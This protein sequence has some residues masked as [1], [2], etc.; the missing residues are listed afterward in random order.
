MARRGGTVDRPSRA[1]GKEPQ[2]LA[3]PGDISDTGQV[4][5]DTTEGESDGGTG[6]RVSGGYCISAGHSAHHMRMG[7]S[8]TPPSSSAKTLRSTRNR[9]RTPYVGRSVRTVIRL[10][11]V[12]SVASGRGRVGAV[13]LEPTR[14]FRREVESLLRLPVTP[15]PQ[16]FLVPPTRTERASPRLTAGC[17]A[18]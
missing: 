18:D 2:T 11:D 5:G 13:G 6:C 16:S 8:A 1:C 9:S 3:T 17:S 7:D 10:P 15:R 14:R 4:V 12:G